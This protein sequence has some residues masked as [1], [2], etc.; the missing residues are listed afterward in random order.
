MRQSPPNP[1]QLPVPVCGL[2]DLKRGHPMRIRTIAALILVQACASR[3]PLWNP[4]ARLDPTSCAPPSATAGPA[5]KLV[6][7][8]GFTFCVPSDWQTS[9]GQS[10]RGGSGSIAWG[11]GTPAAWPL[12]PQV[13]REGVVYGTV[14]V[15]SPG[16][17]PAPSTVPI[18]PASTEPCTAKRFAERVGGFLTDFYHGDCDGR[19][20]TG[21]WWLTAH[22]YVAGVATD[23][24]TAELQLQVYRSV[25]FN[26][27]PEH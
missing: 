25:R 2:A 13:E 8:A 22:A 4:S 24:E 14:T 9:D 7:G 5:W 15:V 19:H 16:Q 12:V 1:P 10:W 23:A 17:M 18:L 21:A 20:S 27:A 6:A 3:P 11:T 26:A